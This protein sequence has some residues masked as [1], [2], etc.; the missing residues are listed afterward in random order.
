MMTFVAEN[1]PMIGLLFFFTF[2]CGVLF[3]ALRPKNATM[4]NEIAQIPLKDD[5][6]GT[7]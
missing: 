5:N 7:R 1:A 4:F 3:Y 2:F 6:H